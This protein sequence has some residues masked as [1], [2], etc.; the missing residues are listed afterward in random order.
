MLPGVPFQGNVHAPQGESP[1]LGSPDSLIR[2]GI[3]SLYSGVSNQPLS[4]EAG[5]PLSGDYPQARGY[6]LILDS[7]NLNQPMKREAPS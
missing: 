5:S 6:L 2:F 1:T 4:L 7:I 3:N